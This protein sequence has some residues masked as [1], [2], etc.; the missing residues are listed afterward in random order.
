MHKPRQDFVP[1]YTTILFD[2][3][4]QSSNCK[5]SKICYPKCP[6]TVWRRS[7][8]SECLLWIKTRKPHAK[9]S[10]LKYVPSISGALVPVERNAKS[11]SHDIFHDKIVI[12]LEEI[13]GPPSSYP[14]G[15]TWYDPANNNF[16]MNI[17]V[18]THA[19]QSN[20]CWIQ[21]HQ[22]LLTIVQHILRSWFRTELTTSH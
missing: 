11:L 5:N 13:S 1:R 6:G 12:S 10:S 19:I 15:S 8:T 20:L 16:Q 17:P 9:N 7:R 21:S 2:F 22:I 4:I 3:S 18:K 14:F